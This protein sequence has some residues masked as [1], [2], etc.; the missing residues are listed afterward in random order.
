MPRWPA[1]QHAMSGV[2]PSPYMP[3]ALHSL[4]TVSTALDQTL[5][6]MTCW[7]AACPDHVVS[8]HQMCIF[9]KTPTG[10]API[11]L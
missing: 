5:T 10:G 11:Q 7:C 9:G 3:G 2:Q 8:L 1:T 6:G 4:P